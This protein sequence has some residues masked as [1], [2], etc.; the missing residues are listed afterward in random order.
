MDYQGLLERVYHETEA[1]RGKGKVADY[2]PA[3]GRVD[4]GRFGIALATVD[5]SLYTTGDVDKPFSIQSISKVFTLALA[6]KQ[7]GDQVWKRVGKEPSGHPFNSLAQ[8][9]VEQGVPRNPFINGGAL[10]ITDILLDHLPRPLE[11]ILGFIRELS[12]SDSVISDE[13]VA[14]SEGE[15]GDRNAALA[16]FMKSFENI[17]HGVDDVLKLYFSH[18]AITMD[19]ISLARAFLFLADGGRHPVTGE[20]VLTSSLTKR[21]NSLMMTSGLY[22]ESGEF[23]YRVGLPSKSGVGGGIVSILPGH[24]S[25]AL[26]GPEL[27]ACGNSLRGIEA[28]DRFTTYSGLSVF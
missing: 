2:I 20:Q 15:K 17:R 18:C 21:L 3:L 12:G 4:P 16:H 5:G 8:L 22:N 10:V 26:W 1:F 27:N 9:E 6:L 23:A 19:C 7:E 14:L 13:E 28:L 11:E 25:L 24:F